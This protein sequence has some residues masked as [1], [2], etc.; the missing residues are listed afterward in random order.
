MKKQIHGKKKL[1]KEMIMSARAEL[2]N[3]PNEI[4]DEI[5]L[6]LP[7][8]TLLDF[9]C[10]I[11]DYSRFHN[12]N[13]IKMHLNRQMEMDN[14]STIIITT[15]TKIY[16]VNINEFRFAISLDFPFRNPTCTSPILVAGSCNGLV[17]LTHRSFYGE[18][19]YLWNPATGDFKQLPAHNNDVSP[20]TSFALGF[21]YDHNSGKFKVLAVSSFEERKAG[22]RTGKGYMYTLGTSSWRSIGEVHYPIWESKPQV[23]EG[24]PHWIVPDLKLVVSFCVGNEKFKEIPMPPFSDYMTRRANLTAMGGPLSIFCYEYRKCYELW[25][26]M[27]DGLENTS[28]TKQLSLDDSY[29]PGN[30]YYY[31]YLEKK[32]HGFKNGQV[33]LQNDGPALFDPVSKDIT[34]LYLRGSPK[35]FNVYSYTESL[36]MVTVEETGDVHQNL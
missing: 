10:I 14:G 29:I 32:L 7:V 28:W 24:C 17:C 3:L 20:H 26:W 13:F 11:R 8:K 31:G 19:V 16:K 22:L 23:F 36:A 33:L 1:R 5:F 15:A 12:P 27:D 21:G 25:V 18:F 6:R 2:P 9:R 35:G 30:Y 34:N 4:K